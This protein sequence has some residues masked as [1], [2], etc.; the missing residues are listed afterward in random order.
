MNA[1]STAVVERRDASP[2]DKLKVN[3]SSRA[4]EFK[5]ALP[6][7]ISVEK[8]Q[9]TI[10]TAA[11]SNPTLLE[12]DRKSLLLASIKLAQDGLLPDGRE[13]ALVPFK[14]RFKGEDNEWY[15]RW[16][17]QPMP[18]V[19]GLRKKILQ[20]GQVVSL[21][22]GVV[23][24]AEAESGHFIYEIGLDP[25]IRHR[26]NLELS[27]EDMCD[28]N[29]VAAYS[30]ARIRNDH[31][32][33]YWSVEVMRRSEINKVR[34]TSQTGAVGRVVKFGKNKG[35]PIEPKGPWVD[36][37]GEMARKTVLRRHSKV[38]PMSGDIL[39]TLDRE[40][41]AF[42]AEGAT[43]ILATE[44][45][46]PLR[47][48][49]ADELDEDGERVDPDTGEITDNEP[50]RDSR[51]MTEVNEETA[52]ALDRGEDPSDGTLSEDNPAAAEGP[53]DEQR[54]ENTAPQADHVG[55]TEPKNARHGESWFNP[56][57]SEEGRIK[58]AHQTAGHGVKWYLEPPKDD[59]PGTSGPASDVRAGFSR[60]IS[61]VTTKAHLDAVEKDFLKV[62]A[63][64][65]DEDVSE[66]EGKLRA[67][68]KTLAG[69]A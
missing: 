41:E 34:Q 23:Y 6:S 13:A 1:P 68:R 28:D 35:K 51:G 47:L 61:E 5:V 39:D 15:D 9:R 69:R 27:E 24:R 45:K 43:R 4:D 2:I 52:R 25:P 60:R 38:L 33:A 50:K 55:P 54:G 67:K 63:T 17:I 40:D 20:S 64:M 66:I 65:G 58:Y 26:P 8:F 30:I 10:A 16:V 29:I 21:E 31:G 19:Y 62:S 22:T 57:D 32:D 59:A 53:A 44:E 36:W 42:A 37:F 18:M 56:D 11:M 7:H 49:D 14:E 46:G 48:P 3:L 12:C